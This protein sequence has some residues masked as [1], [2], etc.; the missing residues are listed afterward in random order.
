MKPSDS[1][2]RQ[3]FVS[4]DPDDETAPGVIEQVG[5]DVL[6]WASDYPH[7]D[8][9]FPGAVKETLEVLSE[10]PAQSRRKLLGTNGLRLYGLDAPR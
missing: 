3:C 6:V 8:S 1:F 2:Q 5:D 10:V 9:P 4:M 7:I